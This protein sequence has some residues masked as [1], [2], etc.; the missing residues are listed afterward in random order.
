MRL[1]WAALKQLERKRLASSSRRF[2]LAAVLDQQVR[3][4][5][6]AS[7]RDAFLGKASHPVNQPYPLS[8][9]RNYTVFIA[10]ALRIGWRS[11]GVLASWAAS[12][13]QARWKAIIAAH[14]PVFHSCLIHSVDSTSLTTKIAALFRLPQVYRKLVMCADSR[15]PSNRRTHADFRQKRVLLSRITIYN[16]L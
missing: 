8:S 3:H 6:G 9:C 12:A 13:D 16:L 15:N 2:A 10:L 7:R 1:F 14:L 5:A 4:A 11:Q